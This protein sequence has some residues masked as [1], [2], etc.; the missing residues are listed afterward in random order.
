M[1]STVAQLVLSGP[2]HVG[3]PV[4]AYL[5]PGTG[6]MAIQIVG[7]AMKEGLSW[8]AMGAHLSARCKKVLTI[9]EIGPALAERCVGSEY[10]ENLS[11]AVARAKQLARPGD[12]I[13]LSPG[14]ASYDQY[15]NY[16]QRGQHFAQLAKEI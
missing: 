11:A 12:V 10:L 6:S 9:G 1:F 3:S 4:F 8:D 14:T 13:L 16:E 15:V 2:D 7:G 5:D